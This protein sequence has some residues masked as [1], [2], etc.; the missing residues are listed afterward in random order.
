MQGSEAF[1][2][3]C[4]VE[5]HA[6]VY[7]WTRRSAGLLMGVADTLNSLGMLKNKQRDHEAAQTLFQESLK[8]KPCLHPPWRLTAPPPENSRANATRLTPT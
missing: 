8:V 4:H 1:A 5:L 6:H 7:T 3:A 2:H